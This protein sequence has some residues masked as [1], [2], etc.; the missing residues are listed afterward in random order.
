MRPIFRSYLAMAVMTAAF[1]SAAHA[2]VFVDVF[3]G[4]TWTTRTDLSLRAEQP[5]IDGT[6]V[7][8]AVRVDVDGLEPR[9]SESFGARIG[10]W[11]GILGFALDGST[12]DPT[13]QPGTV[14]A[15]ASA[16]FDETIF[17]RPVSIGTGEDVTVDL[18]ELPLPTTMTL[19]ALAMV[20]LPI[21]K[22]DRNRQGVIQPY[23]F[24]GPV[25]LVTNDRFDGK[26]GL[27]L[28]GGLKVPLGNNFALFGEYRYTAVDDADV[29]AG[30]LNAAANGVNASTGDIIGRIDIR[31]HA[32]VAGV[33]LSF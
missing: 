3:A 28:G 19:A 27:R 22:S 12:L 15:S 30:R 11:S 13:L 16:A 8:V 2:E 21:G 7:P 9:D 26:I 5:T 4:K 18:P 17:G 10:F 23:G 31:T 1:P 32:G 14:R 25:W 33:S 29:K 24:A 6:G 20:R